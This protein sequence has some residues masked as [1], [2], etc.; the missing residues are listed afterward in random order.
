MVSFTNITAVALMAR[1][2]L[3][4]TNPGSCLHKAHTYLGTSR[5][6]AYDAAKEV[7]REL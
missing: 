2:I 4:E 1:I 5:M 7:L 3:K 6:S